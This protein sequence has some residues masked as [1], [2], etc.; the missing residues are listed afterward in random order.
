MSGAALQGPEVRRCVSA[1]PGQGHRA[2][3]LRDKGPEAVQ[4]HTTPPGSGV[5]RG[6]RGV[7]GEVFQEPVALWAEIWVR[8]EK[9]AERLQGGAHLER[10]REAGRGRCKAQGLRAELGLAA[11][12]AAS[13]E[14]I[15]SPRL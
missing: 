14:L 9:G 6:A 1:P 4:P 10:A 15:F 12:R 13:C 2:R 7:Q 8:E 11:K 5:T 3:D